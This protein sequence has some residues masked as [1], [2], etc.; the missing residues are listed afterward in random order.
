VLEL[1]FRS[2]RSY[3]PA[4]ARSTR[5][6]SAL[7][8]PGIA[9]AIVPAMPD[10]SVVNCVVYDDVRAL[11]AALDELEAAYDRAGVRAWTV[12]VHEGDERAQE[13]LAAA[14]HVLDAAPMG[15]ERELAGLD[16]P[17][18]G[19]LDLVDEPQPEDLDQIER[20][21]YGWPGF[22]G[23]VVSF[24]PGL[25]AYVAR[26]AGRAACCLGIWD[27]DGDAHVQM[28]GTI[29]EARGQGLAP[30]LLRRALVDAR[31]RGCVTT[32]L[33]ATAMGHPV[34]SR[35]GYRDLGRVQM[36]ERRRPAPPG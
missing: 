34:Y 30:R 11:E 36:W 5:G 29:P 21:A 7:E 26:H 24:A 35:L 31:E 18:A 15:Q 13:L 20:A 32:T 4:F 17:P 12:W 28:V 1:M 8:L 33:Q 27:A 6:G 9:A 10:R 23:A 19:D 22:A 2:M 14:G 3:W 16:A 25:H